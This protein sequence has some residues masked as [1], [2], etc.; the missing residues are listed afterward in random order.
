MRAGRGR[1][2][3]EGNS[4]KGVKNILIILTNFV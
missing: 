1:G 4:S 3:F 2:H